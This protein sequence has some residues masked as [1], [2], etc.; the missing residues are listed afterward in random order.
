MAQHRFW[1]RGGMSHTAFL[2]DKHLAFQG[3]GACSRQWKQAPQSPHFAFPQQTMPNASS[4][5]VRAFS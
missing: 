5:R 4:S 3:N 1:Q 2:L